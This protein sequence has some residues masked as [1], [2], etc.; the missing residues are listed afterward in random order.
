MSCTLHTNLGD[1]K[2]ELFCE[3]TPRAAENFL[4]LCAS[5]YYDGTSFHSNIKGFMVQVRAPRPRPRPRPRS[6][7]DVVARPAAPL[8]PDAR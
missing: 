2:V 8:R 6:R 5:G 4:A 3:D 1:L 7:V